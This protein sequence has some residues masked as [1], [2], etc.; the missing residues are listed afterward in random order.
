[1]NLSD[2]IRLL[3]QHL[4]LMLGTA[5]LMGA[6]VFVLT[7]GYKKEYTSKTI[8]NTGLVSGYT[9]ERHSSGSHTDREYAN[10]ELMNLVTLSMA[11][12]TMEELSVLLIAQYL[13]VREP[14]PQW[15]LAENFGSIEK[16]LPLSLREALADSTLDQTAFNVRQ[17]A[18]SGLGNPVERLIHSDTEYFGIDYLKKHYHS[19]RKPSSDLLEFTGV[20]TDPAICQHSLRLW[21]GIFIK[22]QRELKESQSTSVLEFFR[23]ATEET[24]AQ[25]RNAEEKLLAFQVE[26]KIINYYEQTRFIADRKE[27]LDEAYFNENME[28]QA[29]QSALSN[30]ETQLGNKVKLSK[31]N[32]ELLEKRKELTL[33]ADMLAKYELLGADPETA[34]PDKVKALK[35][36]FEELQAGIKNYA[37][38]AFAFNQTPDGVA[39]TEVLLKWLDQVVL[40]EKAKARIKAYGQRQQ[41]FSEIYSQFAPWGSSLKKIEREIAL[42]EDAYLENLHSYNQA[43]LH[44]QNTLMSANLRVLDA[45]FYPTEAAGSKRLLLVI[46]AFLAG[47]FLVLA[48]ALV[49]EFTDT[50]L[51]NP[52]EIKRIIGLNLLGVLPAFPAAPYRRHKMDYALLRTRAASLLTQQINLETYPAGAA[53]PRKILFA[54]T[55]TQEGKT[56]AI[57]VVLQQLRA[58]MHRVLYLYPASSAGAE[59]HPDNHAYAEGYSFF[60]LQEWQELAPQIADWGSYDYLILEIPALLASQYPISIVRQADLAVLTVRSDRAWRAADRMALQTLQRCAAGP[61]RLLLNGAPEGALEDSFGDIPQKPGAWRWRAKRAAAAAGLAANPTR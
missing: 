49:L 29:M 36:R 1:M 12:E 48:L 13:M 17:Y 39:T 59:Q 6:T 5:F 50:T 57:E 3:R 52:L 23:R 34:N 54:S 21:S 58:S 28:M 40:F 55:R 35:T 30:L 19:E 25:L 32:D 33:V 16:A 10:N 11:H 7:M 45:P 41:E 24:A 18:Q 46:A 26:N 37:Q 44:M 51:K 60:N 4:R 22:K 27:D 47:F 56:F 53:S 61:V 38:K 14:D 20:S 42:A 9:I 43:R 2:F 31:L 8:I 15:V